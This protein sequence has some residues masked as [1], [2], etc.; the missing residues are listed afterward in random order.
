M[1]LVSF[2]WFSHTNLIANMPLQKS[3]P[4]SQKPH[5]KPKITSTKMQAK[6]SP[7]NGLKLNITVPS[8]PVSSP[9]SSLANTA[10]S[11]AKV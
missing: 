8:H 11:S 10:T 9:I 6:K 3:I 7:T 4:A 2:L 5:S 1:S